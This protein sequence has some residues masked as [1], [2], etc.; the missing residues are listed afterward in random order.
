M[1]PTKIQN[2]IGH[3]QTA[4]SGYLAVAHDSS[5]ERCDPGIRMAFVENSNPALTSFQCYLLLTQL[6]LHKH[7][8]CH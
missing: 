5:E 7:N 4:T 8:H 1:N 2:W 3:R 6:H